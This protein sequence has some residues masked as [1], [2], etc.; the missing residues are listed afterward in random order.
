MLGVQPDRRLV[1]NEELRLV[2]GRPCDIGESTPTPRELAGGVP[3]A[4]GQPGA[5]EGLANRHPAP[6]AVEPGQ[7]GGEE[8]IFLHREQAVDAGLLK[9]EPESPADRPT[10]TGDVVTENARP[11]AGGR[12]QRRQQQHG[13][14]LAGTVRTQQADQRT[15]WNLKV[16][17]DEGPG[18]PIVPSQALSM[19]REGV[20]GCFTAR[21]G[22]ARCGSP[23]RTR[24]S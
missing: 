12:E 9:D 5:V 1:Q 20:L 2:Q 6:L 23:A 13:G 15:A 8:Q 11:P 7:P 24:Y 19:D 16:E 22:H 4:W 21:A 3:R 10:L 14:R 17:C 18:R